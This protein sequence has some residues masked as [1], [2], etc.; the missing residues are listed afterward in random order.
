MCKEAEIQKMND[1]VREMALQSYG[2]G[3][4]AARYWFIGPEQGQGGYENND[5]KPRAEAWRYFG[6]RELDD[7]RHFHARINETRWESELQTTWRRLMLLFMTFLAR[8]TDEASLLTY[9]REKWG[10]LNGE[11]CVIELS[12]LAAKSFKTP[13]NRRLFRNER[14]EV[15][16][17]RM[18]DHKPELLVMY[19]LSHKSDFQKITEQRFPPEGILKLGATIMALALHPVAWGNR[20]SDDYWVNLGERLRRLRS[21]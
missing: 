7:C 13:R 20:A 18:L 6:G 3:R 12:G 16:R 9:Q 8:P 4:W 14:I 11:T 1:D 15:I 5:L 21:A 19:G 17:K 2:Y 10:A